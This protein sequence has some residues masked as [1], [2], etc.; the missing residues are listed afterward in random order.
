MLE[1]LRY[2]PAWPASIVVLFC[3]FMQFYQQPWQNKP[4]MEWDIH[5]YY[6]YLPNTFISGDY[7]QRSWNV[8]SNRMQIFTFELDKPEKMTAGLS[9]LYAPSF[10][11]A[12]FIA[13]ILGY[14]ADGYSI[15]YRVALV[16]AIYPWLWLGLFYLYKVILLIF[17]KEW[18]AFW[19]PLLLFFNTNLYHYSIFENAMSHAFTFSLMSLFMYNALQWWRTGLWGY[20]IML[21]L[22]AGMIVWIRPV[23]I[24]LLAF[25]VFAFQFLKIEFNWKKHWL[26]VAEHGLFAVFLAF[27]VLLPQL[28]YW[29]HMSG[30]WIYYSYGEEGFFWA[31]SKIFSGLFSFRKG[32]FVYSPTLLLII[33]GFLALWSRFGKATTALLLLIS[34]FVYI[35]FAWWCWW[36]GGGFG[37][38]TLV[39][40]YPLLALPLAA[41]LNFL[42]RIHRYIKPVVVAGFVAG[43]ALNLFQTW[44]Y[45]EGIIHHHGNTW[46]SYKYAF[47][48]LEHPPGWWDFLYEPNYEKA[49]KG[50]G[51]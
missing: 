48:A 12:H 21:G 7:T 41:G 38:R 10:L 51:R 11:I 42:M 4:I 17:K 20:T 50:K 9:V 31:D 45:Q 47:F 33:P 6:S 22:L 40:A 32:L 2:H 29:K 49:V 8:D 14:A 46:K 34:L 1:K 24:L 30:Q 28:F 18:L 43:M 37:A 15:P 27:V 25:A 26:K 44:Q 5:N 19:I 16:F 3:L 36:Y 13:P 23:N 39:D 35:T